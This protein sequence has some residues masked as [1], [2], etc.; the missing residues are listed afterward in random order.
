MGAAGTQWGLQAY[1]VLLSVS[2]LPRPILQ[3]NMLTLANLW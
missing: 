3:M 2:S 1:S